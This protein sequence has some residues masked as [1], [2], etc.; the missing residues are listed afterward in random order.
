LPEYDFFQLGYQNLLYKTIDEV[1][2]FFANKGYE[3]LFEEEIISEI[4][5]FEYLN[6]PS[7]HPSRKMTDTF[8]LKKNKTQE[9]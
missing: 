3:L 5:N 6:V 2:D 8:F 4:E 9:R 7:Y 1:I